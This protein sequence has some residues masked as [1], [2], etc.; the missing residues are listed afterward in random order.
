[1][2]RSTGT[3]A[4]ASVSLTPPAAVPTYMLERQD[5]SIALASSKLPVM[6]AEV[7]AGSP[8]SGGETVNLVPPLRCVDLATEDEVE[9]DRA[10]VEALRERGL[11]LGTMGFSG[12]TA[13]SMSLCC[14]TLF[15]TDLKEVKRGAMVTRDNYGR[16]I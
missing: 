14:I 6:L 3:A 1:M 2:S 5:A 16:N 7:L 10:E 8:S 9:L 4:E 13:F 12:D 11:R 15:Q